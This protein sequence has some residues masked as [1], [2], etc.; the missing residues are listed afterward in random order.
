MRVGYSKYYF[1]SHVR[2]WIESGWIPERGSLLDFG[3]QAFTGEPEETKQSIRRFLQW[4]N[5]DQQPE[6]IAEIY[7]LIGIDYQRVDVDG[8]STYA[9][10]NIDSVPDDFRGR[11]DF[12][13]NEGTIEHLAN[14]INGFRFAH[15]AVKVGGVVKHSMPVG[16]WYGHGLFYATP[17]FYQLLIEANGYE[18]LSGWIEVVDYADQYDGTFFKEQKIHTTIPG[19]PPGT[20]PAINQ[21]V[22][23]A[24]RK[25]S[26]QAFV[27]P[28][29]IQDDF[30]GNISRQIA[31]AYAKFDHSVWTV[32]RTVKDIARSCARNSYL[33]LA[34]L[35]K[36]R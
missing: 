9:D 34:R 35:L 13:N 7:A 31:E 10:L 3:S 15:D 29:D 30:T 33:R 21:S 32:P 25:T 19:F 2:R 5:I 16:G 11:F 20:Y 6:T 14:P 24:Y 26:P 36:S 23:L 8:A 1:E 17:K 18:F 22:H 28:T 27:V 4:R 12:V